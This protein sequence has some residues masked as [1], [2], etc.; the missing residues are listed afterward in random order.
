MVRP[1]VNQV[2]RSVNE[3]LTMMALCRCVSQ[4]GD[5]LTDHAIEFHVNF[6]FPSG[7]SNGSPIKNSTTPKASGYRG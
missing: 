1:A 6:R 5:P 2:A 4:E 3:K 7:A